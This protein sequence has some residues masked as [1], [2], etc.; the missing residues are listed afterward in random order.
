MLIPFI[1][2]NTKSAFFEFIIINIKYYPKLNI[3]P[4][5]Y[6]SFTF[7]FSYKDF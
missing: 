1:D 2:V 5:F 7:L 3:I 4:S 6:I